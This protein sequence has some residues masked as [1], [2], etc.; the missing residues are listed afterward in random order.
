MIE[1]T[2]EQIESAIL[3]EVVKCVPQGD[4]DRP[5][6]RINRWDVEETIEK[7]KEGT[8]RVRYN[9]WRGGRIAISVIDE[10]KEE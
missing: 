4:R 8:L 5:K 3:A 2:D 7:I 9:E 1:A 6:A 10:S